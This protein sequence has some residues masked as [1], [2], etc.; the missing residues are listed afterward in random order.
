MTTRTRQLGAALAAVTIGLAACGG[1]DGDGAATTEATATVASVPAASTSP[2]A[3]S[4]TV[5]PTT[6]DA[7]ATTVAPTTQAPTTTPA[8]AVL[9]NPSAV[10]PLMPTATCPSKGAAGSSPVSGAALVC[11]D[12][13]GRLSWAAIVQFDLS[14]ETRAA[15]SGCAE[16]LAS[17]ITAIEQGETLALPRCDAANDAVAGSGTDPFLALI[18]QQLAECR[19]PLA[20]YASDRQR[21][22]V[23]DATKAEALVN[24]VF[25]CKSVI[26]GFANTRP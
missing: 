4:I 17:A 18:Q 10:V 16:E 12:L 13:F 14:D 3:P 15:L 22:V 7:P 25:A 8:T 19:L 20:Q 21:G 6:V 24:P 5:A 9:A 26:E 11:L 1:G 23:Y 2:D